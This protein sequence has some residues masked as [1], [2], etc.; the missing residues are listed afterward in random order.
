MT[1][2]Q[3]T[4]VEE[5]GTIRPNTDIVASSA[6]ELRGALRKMVGEGVRDITVDFREVAMLDS[7]GIGLLVAAHNSLTKIGG[8]LAIVHAS[9]DVLELLRTMRIHQHFEISGD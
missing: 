2:A 4:Q 1:Y 9:P 7:S 5:K 3:I 8:R 6:G